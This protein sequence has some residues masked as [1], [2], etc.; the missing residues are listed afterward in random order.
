MFFMSRLLLRRFVLSL[1]FNLRFVQSD[2]SI[3]TSLASVLQLLFCKYAT[4]FTVDV[5]KMP[6][7]LLLKAALH[8]QTVAA[9]ISAR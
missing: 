4:K 8:R 3:Y 1:K 9:Q 5:A 2:G 6:H 7:G